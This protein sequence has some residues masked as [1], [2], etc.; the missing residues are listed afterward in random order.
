MQALP[1]LIGLRASGVAVPQIATRLSHA[2][3][4]STSG[5]AGAVLCCFLD[6]FFR[7]DRGGP[8]P[9]QFDT[10]AGAWQMTVFLRVRRKRWRAQ[11]A[12]ACSSRPCYESLSARLR[13]VDRSAHRRAGAYAHREFEN[14]M[15]S[16]TNGNPTLQMRRGR[17]GGGREKKKGPISN[18]NQSR[19][20]VPRHRDFFHPARWDGRRTR[21][22]QD[23]T[24]HGLARRAR[25]INRIAQW[26]TLAA[27]L[28]PAQPRSS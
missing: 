6:L 28:L 15:L 19:V 11:E 22:R 24:R 27:I 10:D 3:L 4:R 18:P 7:R 21:S 8:L 12:G 13:V 2:L 14:A 26:A 17:E 23:R 25:S 9:L 20:P 1:F 5:N 16:G